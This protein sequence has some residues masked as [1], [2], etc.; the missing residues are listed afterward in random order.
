[1]KQLNLILSA[2]ITLS[3]SMGMLPMAQAGTD[4]KIYPGLM[5]QPISGDQSGDFVHG[6]SGMF[7]KSPSYDFVNCPVVRDNTK[8]LNGTFNVHVRVWQ[9]PARDIDTLCYLYSKEKDGDIV[10][11]DGE[12]WFKDGFESKSLD[13]D[14]S[15]S[16]GYYHIWCRVPAKSFIRSYRV[17][18]H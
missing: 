15:A 10:E 18:E 11:V 3:L 8:N 17:D 12:T 2:L 4:D 1:M 5:C 7:N 13:V 14:T 6:G 16:R 9:S